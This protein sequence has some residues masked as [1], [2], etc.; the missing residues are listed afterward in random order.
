LTGLAENADAPSYGATKYLLTTIALTIPIVWLTIV[1]L[2]KHSKVL[3]STTL[4]VILLFGV[5]IAQPD[6]R[7]AVSFVTADRVVLNEDSIYKEVAALKIALEQNP[8]HVLCV[9][10]FG[11]PADGQE[12][13]MESYFC[14]RWAQSLVGGE[15]DSYDW[16]FAP[17]NRVDSIDQLLP[18]REAYE[19]KE[20]LLVRFTQES[21][22]LDLEET[23]WYKYVDESWE[24]LSTPLIP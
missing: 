9:S 13:R 3:V 10:D 2:L 7:S 23:W 19:G 1:S 4:G 11:F 5:L 21:N 16:R 12:I 6:S 14:T 24:I 17:L 22:K 18:I 15:V 8:D 20:V